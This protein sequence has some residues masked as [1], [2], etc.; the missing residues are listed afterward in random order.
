[1]TPVTS[2]VQH[3]AEPVKAAVDVSAAATVVGALM[4]YLPPVAALFTI[5]WTGIQIF[6]FFEERVKAKETEKE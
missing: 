4:G 6:A 2:G 5:V 3:I 1:M